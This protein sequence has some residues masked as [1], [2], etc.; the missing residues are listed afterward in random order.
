MKAQKMSTTYVLITPLWEFLRVVHITRAQ[1][2]MRANMRVSVAVT[3]YTLCMDPRI[4]AWCERPLICCDRI[5]VLGYNAP[6]KHIYIGLWNIMYVIVCKLTVLSLPRRQ[7][8]LASASVSNLK[9]SWPLPRAFRSHFGLEYLAT[10]NTS[11]KV[12]KWS[13]KRRNVIKVR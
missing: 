3:P 9:W 1:A 8:F 13:R 2:R 4:S 5:V 6:G 10:L 12:S 11:D 7:I